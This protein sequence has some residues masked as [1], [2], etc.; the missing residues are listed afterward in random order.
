MASLMRS[1]ALPWTAVVDGE[2]FAEGAG[3]G[4]G[5]FELGDGGGGGRGWW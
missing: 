1:A 2:A 3:V 5:G 4:V